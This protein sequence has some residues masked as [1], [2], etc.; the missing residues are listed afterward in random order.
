M[1][2]LL[3]QHILNYAGT[4]LLCYRADGDAALAAKQE[5]LWNPWLEW[6]EET[7]GVTL[8][9]TSGIMP[10]GQDE[11]AISRLRN[12][13]ASLP[14][15]TLQPL[16]DLTVLLGSVV[17]ALAVVQ[18]ELAAEGAF[19]LSVLDEMHQSE[20]WGADE[21]KTARLEARKRD[22]MAAAE[23]LHSKTPRQEAK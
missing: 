14:P 5:A 11:A 6:L 19:A 15:Q 1:N 12:N 23:S 7:H 8:R 2:A 10:L 4:D 13:V 16:H 20:R 18:G 17:L 22:I 21:E 9:Y 3:A